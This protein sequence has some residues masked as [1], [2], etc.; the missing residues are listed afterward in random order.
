MSA[1]E[2][3]H[4][5]FS[6]RQI[7]LPGVFEQLQVLSHVGSA[8]THLSL[9]PC[10]DKQFKLQFEADHEL[11]SASEQKKISEINLNYFPESKAIFDQLR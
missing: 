11:L 2:L 1:Q 3:L 5:R 8:V 4:A 7:K 9:D 10:Q 6:F